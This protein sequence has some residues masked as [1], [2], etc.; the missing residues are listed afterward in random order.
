MLLYVPYETEGNDV[1]VRVRV[2]LG[3]LDHYSGPPKVVL[4]R[5]YL[6]AGVKGQPPTVKV[7][8]TAGDPAHSLIVV[9]LGSSVWPNRCGA[10]TVAARTPSV[11]ITAFSQGTHHLYYVNCI[12]TIFLRFDI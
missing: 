1:E 2:M 10:L 11:G 3:R 4:D 9:S 12:N 6:V 7:S 5:N 8:L